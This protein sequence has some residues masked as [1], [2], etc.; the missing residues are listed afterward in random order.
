MGNFTIVEEEP[1]VSEADDF[2]AFGFFE[3]ACFGVFAGTHGEECGADAKL[4]DGLV[5]G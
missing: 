2:R 5:F 3:E 4:G 1:E